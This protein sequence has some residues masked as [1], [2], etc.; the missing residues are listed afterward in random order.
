MRGRPFM[1]ESMSRTLWP[2]TGDFRCQSGRVC[3]SPLPGPHAGCGRFPEAG[4]RMKRAEEKTLRL[5]MF[6]IDRIIILP[7]PC[8]WEQRGTLLDIQWE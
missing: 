8:V 4:P 5:L 3:H 7:R 6:K 1:L 2:C